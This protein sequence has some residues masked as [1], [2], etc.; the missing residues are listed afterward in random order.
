MPEIHVAPMTHRQWLPRR[1]RR[2]GDC[3]DH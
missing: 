2:R 1:R 3:D